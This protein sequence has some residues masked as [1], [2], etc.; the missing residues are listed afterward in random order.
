MLAS[1]LS[2]TRRLLQNPAAP[3][4]LYSDTDLTLAINEAR[5]QL[6][7]EAA[8]IRVMGTLAIT[9]TNPGPYQFASINT[10]SA[11]GVLDVIAV[12]TIWVL[13]GSGQ[14]MLPPRPFE[15]F[16]LYTLNTPVP[17]QAVP[18]IWSQF[19][20]GANGTLYFNVPDQDYSLNLDTVCLPIPLADDTTVEAIP[21]L[22]QSAVQYYATYTALL[23]AQTG[24]RMQEADKMLERYELFVQRARKFA[25]PEVL[26][27]QYS[28]V[29]NPVRANQIGGPPQQGPQGA[30]A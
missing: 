9:A 11:V 30:A 10:S 22:W 17:D 23:G 25:T 8:C 29:P 26:S 16:S 19:G 27:S 20:Q 6:A 13:V 7:A 28:Q 14:V 24:A 15:W 4:P 5:V 1:Y 2:Q 3:V 21:P 12:R 18:N